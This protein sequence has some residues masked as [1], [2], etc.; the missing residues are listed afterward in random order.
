VL[1][2]P[3]E[4]KSKSRQREAYIR[5]ETLHVWVQMQV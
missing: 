4:G 2:T 1:H 5:T 3:M